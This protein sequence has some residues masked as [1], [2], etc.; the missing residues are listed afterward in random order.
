MIFSYNWLKDY[1]KLPKPDKLVELLTMHSFEVEEV[2]KAGK[3]YILDIDVLPNRSHDCLCHW[4]VAREISA[5]TDKDL[6]PLKRKKIKKEKGEIK[7]ISLKIKCPKLVPRYSAIIVEG[8]KVGS[9]PKW[10]K[11]RIES[12]GLRSINNIVDL[13]NYVML[14]TGQPLHAFDYEK[15]KSSQMVLRKSKKGEKLVTLDDSRHTLDEGMLVIEDRNRLIDLVGIMG[16]KLSETSSTT[17]NIVLQAGNFDRQT[18]YKTARKLNHRTE[19][20]N[21]YS[22]G[23]DPNLTIS[24]LERV[25][26]LLT[27]LGGGKIVQITDIYPRKV[28]PKKIK[29]D[30]KYVERLLGIRISAK[31]V[32]NILER[33]GFKYANNIVEVPSFRMDVSLQED[34]IEEIGRIYGYKKVSATF[35]VVSLIPPKRNFEIF[36][37]DITKNIL[38][39]GGFTEVYNYSFIGKKEAEIF[40]Y[41]SKE[42]IEV[43]NPMSVE[44][45]YL[46]PSLIPNLLKNVIDNFRYFNKIKIF[47]LGKIFREQEKRMLSGLIAQKQG[48][49]E[50][51]RLKGIV[52]S[53]LSKLGISNV[54]YDEYKPTP[55]QS[56]I[57]IWQ[58][59]KCAEIKVDGQEIG[60]L[61]E[62]SSRIFKK[63]KVVVFD[64][65][66]EEL[67]KLC[68]EEHEYQPISQYPAAIRD[69]AVL[70]PMNIKVV[71]VLNKINIAGGALIRDVDLFD[72]YEGEGI[73]QGKKNLAFHIIYQAEDRTLK[74]KE[75]DKIQN[76]IIKVL[77]SEVNW[78]VR[79]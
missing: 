42:I 78:E 2:K 62:I 24:T 14:E 13:T 60:F 16:G 61:G 53:L 69:L 29:L 63:T 47:E 33:L 20:S 1:T 44:Q 77:E 64:I 17:K 73:P 11:E 57:S 70:V 28:Q 51:Y 18:I 45:K 32:K 39:E 8:V 65:D 67:A 55:E 58:K 35:P 23:I 59:G 76:K 6:E 71:D 22:Q 40:K 12:V 46:R 56:K 7:P 15:I 66:F 37:E 52:D 19:A 9:S 25:C 31:Q 75:I 21:I 79:R 27:K 36:W 4:G 34:L 10:L 72:I 50:F 38:K 41:K 74:A 68:S 43:E 30:L 3:D 54:W 26:F 5:I 48:K 49:A